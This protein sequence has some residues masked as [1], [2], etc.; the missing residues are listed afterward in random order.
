MISE[1]IDLQFYTKVSINQR[2]KN[3]DISPELFAAAVADLEKNFGT[4]MDPNGPLLK[5]TEGNASKGLTELFGTD[6]K[7][8]IK[9][10]RNLGFFEKTDKVFSGTTLVTLDVNGRNL[11]ILGTFSVVRVNQRLVFLFAYK[12]FPEAKDD[13]MLR[14]FTMKWS[15]KTVAAN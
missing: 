6:T 14:D 7:T 8:D 10:A 15:A 5:K 2:V 11:T 4:Y 9:G 3:T 13:E 1:D 12:M